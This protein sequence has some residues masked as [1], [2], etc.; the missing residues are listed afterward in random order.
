MRTLTLIILMLTTA[1]FAADPATPPTR[2]TTAPTTQP[3]IRRTHVFASGL[4]QGVNYRA[5]VQSAATELK[6]VGW[7]KNLADSRVEAEIEG[8]PDKVEEL[9]T[10][11]KRGPA[12]ARV[13]KLEMVD[14][15]PL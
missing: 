12:A 9:L 15:K 11:M 1:V 7:V 10:R 14:Q 8:P 6:L 5:F 2:P 13:D 4:V 3:A